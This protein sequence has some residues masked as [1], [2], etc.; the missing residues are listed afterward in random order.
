MVKRKPYATAIVGALVCVLVAGWLLLQWRTGSREP[1][2]PTSNKL[3]RDDD[4]AAPSTTTSQTERPQR[5][6]ADDAPQPAAHR[7]ITG[8]TVLPSGQPVLADVR[9]TPADG[10]G[11]QS[12][13]TTSN[14]RG[15]FELRVPAAW[16]QVDLVAT[17]ESGARGRGRLP[18]GHPGEVDIV[19]QRLVD[20]TLRLRRSPSVA[21]AAAGAVDHIATVLVQ[22]LPTV[23]LLDL[24]RD[25][26]VATFDLGEGDEQATTIR[27]DFA[28]HNTITWFTS[29]ADGQRSLCHRETV[30][31]NVDTFTSECLL[32]VDKLLL[33][34]IVDESGNPLPHV[35][36]F[37]WSE[38]GVRRQVCTTDERGRCLR[39]VPSG[40]HGRLE[41]PWR[42]TPWIEGSDDWQRDPESP[43]WSAG[44]LT[45]VVADMGHVL[46][47]RFVDAQGAPIR[48]FQWS[49][50]NDGARTRDGEVDGRHGETATDVAY[51]F[52]RETLAAGTPLFVRPRDGTESYAV[53]T[54]DLAADEGVH[55]LQLR[56]VTPRPLE[57]R[58]A[59]S[60]P[61]KV[62]RTVSLRLESSPDDPVRKS[63]FVSFTRDARTHAFVARDVLPGTYAL[64]ITQGAPGA[65]GRTITLA[66][67]GEWSILLE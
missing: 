39:F 65:R 18:E 10:T 8:S 52:S 6:R 46:R 40:D 9:A 58:L 62:G 44:S 15:R 5:D 55:T 42:Y 28:E 34:A 23:S 33:V 66:P 37:A 24:T 67:E 13:S 54:K 4:G 45:R 59:A 38:P 50:H 25:Q 63:Y 60:F 64:T 22:K 47:V 19:L 26:H 43:A 57:L 31:A 53:A 32:D 56:Q 36:F 21:E 1:T 51:L 3:A 17:S 49:D 27:L 35:R 48:S 41:L 29:A 12:V 11:D 16:R 14:E 30:P 2:A 20:V 7:R 61:G